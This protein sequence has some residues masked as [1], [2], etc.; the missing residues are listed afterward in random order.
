[1]PAPAPMPE[2]P[3]QVQTQIIKKGGACGVIALIISI[4]TLAAVGG[5]GAYAYFKLLPQLNSK[6]D[7]KADKPADDATS[8]D[9]AETPAAETPDADADS[10]DAPAAPAATDADTSAADAAG[11]D[12]SDDNGST[13]TPAATPGELPA[14]A[15]ANNGIHASK[16]AVMEAFIRAIIARDVDA[17][18]ECIAPECRAESIRR[19]GNERAAKNALRINMNRDNISNLQNKINENKDQLITEWLNLAENGEGII[20]VNGKWY[21][22]F[23]F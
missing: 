6:I 1:M 17:A 23:K 18:W 19:N 16:Q 2:L 22:Q 11:A 15:P 5:G 14:P 3:P 4:L 12:D 7:A 9:D 21:L 10:D 20:E 13:I 8:T